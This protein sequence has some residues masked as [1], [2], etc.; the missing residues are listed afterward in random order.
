[1]TNMNDITIENLRH[2]FVISL[3]AIGGSMSMT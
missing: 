1:M 2:M 3:T